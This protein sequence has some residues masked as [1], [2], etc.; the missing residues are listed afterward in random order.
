MEY[1]PG[2]PIT[3]Y[4]D[5][6]KLNIRQRLELF[7]QVCEGVQHAHQKSIMH[8]DLKPA[9]V[10]VVEVDGKPM[11][12]IIDFG[13][14]KPAI[15]YGFGDTAITV[16]GTPIGTPA[17]MSP[18]QAD[19]EVRD[20]DTRTDVYSLGVLLYELLTGTLPFDM[21]EWE[22]KPLDFVLKQVREKATPRPSTHFKKKASAH[23]KAAST[24]ADMRGS[25]SGQLGNLLSGDLD[26]ITMKALEKDRV[27][28][29]GSP[30]D[31]SADITRYLNNE[32]VL[33]GP[34]TAGYR[35]K[36]YVVRH[37]LALGFGAGILILLAGFVVAQTVALR[38]ITQERDRATRERDRA[39]RITDFMTGIFKVSKPSEARG[40]TVTDRE[41]LDEAS[42]DID[43]G[44]KKDLELQ[45]RMMSVMGDVYDN[46]G[47]ASRAQLLQQ[48]AIE[49][50]QR[51]LGPESPETL[52]SMHALARSISQ[53]SHYPEAEALQRQALDAQRH[54]LGPEHP[55]TLMAVSNLANILRLEGR[56]P[57]AEKLTRETIDIR[58]RL[59]GPEKPETLRSI[60]ALA[61]I[62]NSEGRF[63]EQEAILR[64]TLDAQT[65]VLGP[66]HPDTLISIRNL[67][68]VLYTE[69]HYD[70]AEKLH[71][72]TL[73][74]DR[75]I[76]GPEHPETLR[77][78]NNLAN[79]LSTEGHLAEA[80]Q[81]YRSTLDVER[82]VLGPEDADTLLSINNLA[83]VLG[84]EGHNAESEKL[85]QQ[86][87]DVERRVLGPENPVTLETMN[88]LADN[89]ID[90]HDYA[91]AEKL[92]KQALDIQRRTPAP[93]IRMRRF[94]P[95]TLALLRSTK[96]AGTKH[97]RCYVR[98]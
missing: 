57:E 71:R 27:R 32:P 42:T 5:Q 41:I 17:Y 16:A 59:L 36:K 86:T 50:Q 90:T 48:H 72:E 18:E 35:L 20:V 4:C 6:R 75:R 14:A 49:I 76:F 73:D 7:V 56:Y 10:L 94:L 22:N 64:Q 82:R 77:S 61:N 2:M 62:L 67:A 79:V 23:Q 43:T 89:L 3:D 78:A 47:L 9:N 54:I 21:D 60:V 68:N 26:W 81:L 13:L 88:D 19:P 80:E 55:D 15:P 53:Q 37:R 97:S 52:R 31:L 87:F 24:A 28:R 83:R 1:V 85:H 74:V 84:M 63:A 44:L 40:N 65:R 95:I 66:E 45:A 38:R 70:E 69:G 33:A 11:P 96:A 34:A 58:T 51:V 92:L 98:L 8:R 39:T 46:L 12:R 29:Y 25:D 91:G 93:T 30:S